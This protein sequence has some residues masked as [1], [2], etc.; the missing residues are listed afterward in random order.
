VLLRLLAIS[1]EGS[2]SICDIVLKL[3]LVNKYQ[4]CTLYLYLVDI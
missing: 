4:V 3:K 1:D 2:T